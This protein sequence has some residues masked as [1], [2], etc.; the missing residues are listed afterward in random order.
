MNQR[1]NGNRIEQAFVQQ[2]GRNVALP[3]SAAIQM[4]AEQQAIAEDN[5]RRIFSMELAKACAV[6]MSASAQPPAAIGKRAFA[7][8][9]SFMEEFEARNKPK[10][11]P[12]AIATE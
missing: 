9:D 3:A 2:A 6:A 5:A 8:A 4:S 7:I 1:N 10:E 11:S 12:P